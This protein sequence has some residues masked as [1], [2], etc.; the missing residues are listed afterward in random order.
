[1]K[2]RARI[3]P[4]VLCT[5][6]PCAGFLRASDAAEQRSAANSTMAVSTRSSVGVPT[7]LVQTTNRRNVTASPEPAAKRPV[8]G[9]IP[10]PRRASGVR[11]SRF[12]ML[13]KS[14]Q[15]VNSRNPVT[16][17]HPISIKA[18]A[19]SKPK[20][21]DLRTQ[22]VSSSE[23]RGDGFRN[24]HLT[25]IPRGIGGPGKTARDTATLSGTG[26]SRGRLN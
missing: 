8:T 2:A 7:A 20:N 10:L 25:P 22:P 4:I 9:K 6:V 21:R 26:M 17:P 3:L 15:G 24:R 16:D 14:N 11:A 23:I 12:R 19:L 5:L 13:H 18:I 1:M